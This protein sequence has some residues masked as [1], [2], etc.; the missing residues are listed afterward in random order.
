MKEFFL[1]GVALVLVV[2][3]WYSNALLRHQAVRIVATPTDG[4]KEPPIQLT[5]WETSASC[6]VEI[7]DGRTGHRVLW[8]VNAFGDQD[9]AEDV[10]AYVVRQIKTKNVQVRFGK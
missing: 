10:L 4:K 1:F 9:E 2:A 6:D 7:R 3:I 8:S 5:I